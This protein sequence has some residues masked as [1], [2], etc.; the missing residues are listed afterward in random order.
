MA[1]KATT[2]KAKAEVEKQLN[3][4]LAQGFRGLEVDPTPNEHYT[5]GGVLAGKPTP[6]SDPEHAKKVRDSR[7]T[8]RV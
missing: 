7:N 5:V 4:E 6:E 3:A 2:D 1:E 8:R